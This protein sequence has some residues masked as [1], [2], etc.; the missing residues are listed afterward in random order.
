[1]FRAHLHASH[2]RITIG[3]GEINFVSN[4]DLLIVRA[5]CCEDHGAENQN[6]SQDQRHVSEPLHNATMA[7]RNSEIE[8][9]NAAARIPAQS[10]FSSISQR[11]ALC[12]QT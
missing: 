6:L 8:I 10:R 5:A 11:R 1:M 12:A 3:V 4:E 9:K 2:A 7:N